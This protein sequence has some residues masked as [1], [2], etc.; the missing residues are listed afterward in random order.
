MTQTAEALARTSL[1]INQELFGGD[2]EELLVSAALPEGCIELKGSRES[3]S[4]RAG[5]TALVTAFILVARM[6]VGIRLDI[7][8]VAVIDR[9]PPLCASRLGEA[10]ADLGRD[11]IPGVPIPPASGPVDATFSFG[12]TGDSDAIQVTAGDLEACLDRFVQMGESEGRLPFGGLAA[13]TAVAA[14]AFEAM[15]PRIE[16]RV[17]LCARMP[18]PSPGPPVRIDLGQLFPS[19]GEQIPGSL[20]AIEAVSGGAIT[21]ALIFCLLRVPE[22]EVGIRV[23]E[24]DVADLTNLN[25]YMLLRRSQVGLH[26]VAHL[27]SATAKRVKVDG[28]ELLFNGKTRDRILPLADRVLVGVDDVQARWWVQE[29]EPRWLAV[30]ATGN[31]LAQLSVHIPGGPCAGCV[32]GVPLPPQTIPTISFVS[33]WAGLL[34]ACALLSDLREPA[35]VSVYPFALGGPMS[36]TSLA[37][38]HSPTCPVGCGAFDR[39]PICDTN[40]TRLETA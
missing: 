26:K 39:R 22:L 6:G 28:I 3:L 30:G 27:R 7:P 25:R 11:L 40:G 19:L 4:T 13:G 24:D 8:D 9:V 36:F 21:N 23:I 16:S 12:D 14:V 18:R 31:H 33:F 32:H 38:Q 37:P 15:V 5:Q 35:N 1:L 29:A 10:L 2:A 34:Q 17:G 20:G